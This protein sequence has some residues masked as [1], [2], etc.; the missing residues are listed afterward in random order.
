LEKLTSPIALQLE[1]EALIAL[2]V[3]MTLTREGFSVVTFSRCEDAEQWLETNTPHVAIIDV[4]LSDGPSIAAVAILIERNTPFIV[5]SGDTETSPY[6]DTVFEA[7]VWIGKPAPTENIVA[8]ARKMV[9]LPEA[10][11]G[12]GA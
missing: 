4:E 3:E 9:G 10:S 1:D 2:D 6:R 8:T 7:G 12:E 5:H 11:P